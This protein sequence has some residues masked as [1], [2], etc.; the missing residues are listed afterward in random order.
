MKKF[1]SIICLFLISGMQVF[2]VSTKIYDE[3]GFRLGT[4][5]KNGETYEVFDL[6]GNPITKD[7]LNNPV[8]SKVL[9]FY[10]ISGN[11]IR[12]SNEKRTISP[13]NIKYNNKIYKGPIYSRRELAF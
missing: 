3:N 9:Y 8:P 12:F 5:T 13:I 6:D 2:A 7:A 11:L 4:C 10:D 1:F